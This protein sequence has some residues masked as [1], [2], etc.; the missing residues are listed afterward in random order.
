MLLYSE[1]ATP[2]LLILCRF[3]N[4]SAH[5]RILKSEDGSSV[6]PT[7]G[8]GKKEST[9]IFSLGIFMARDFLKGTVVSGVPLPSVR[10][11]SY[12]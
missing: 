12:R 9:E 4:L 3:P 10:V 6:L 5:S 8:S 2:S 11:L 7:L 1:A